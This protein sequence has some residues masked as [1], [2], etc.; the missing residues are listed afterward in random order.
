[1]KG[2]QENL[3]QHVVSI[4]NNTGYSMSSGSSAGKIQV[5]PL[6]E[7]SLWDG[8]CMSHLYN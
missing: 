7:L 4:L 2:Q 1:M 5:T 6:N 8:V 3:G